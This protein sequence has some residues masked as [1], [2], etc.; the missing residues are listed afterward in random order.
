M[1]TLPEIRVQGNNVLS[2]SA[3]CYA[4]EI[5]PFFDPARPTATDFFQVNEDVL[6]DQARDVW[7]HKLGYRIRYGWVEC[8]CPACEG[9]GVIERPSTGEDMECQTCEGSGWT[10]VADEITDEMYG[11][12]IYE[13]EI[14]RLERDLWDKWQDALDEVLEAILGEHDLSFE[15]VILRRGTGKARYREHGYRF[16]PVEGKTWLDVAAHL[17][18]TINGYGM[19]EF[20]DAR[21]LKDS[22]PSGSYRQSVMAH[23]HWFKRSTDVYGTRSAKARMDHALEG[24]YS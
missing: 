7:A 19:F 4:F 18:A 23:F 6:A 11:D 16:F 9:F 20:D 1:K 3:V 21:D 24:V 15:R 13:A 10:N 12:P 8:E 2:E 22:V 14:G 5:D 17:V